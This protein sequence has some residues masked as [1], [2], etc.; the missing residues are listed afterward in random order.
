MKAKIMV[1]AAVVALLLADAPLHGGS[2][3]A[4]AKNRSQSLLTDDTARNVGDVLTIV[5]EEQSKIENASERKLEKSDS[6]SAKV[7]GPFDLLRGLNQ[8][9]GKLFGLDKMDFKSDADNKFD[10]KAQMDSSRKVEDKITVTVQD[11]LPNGNLVVLGSR[12]RK[13]TGDSQIVQVSG[14]VRPSDIT[15]ANAV[16]SKQVADFHIVY[17]SAGQENQTTNPGWLGR[18]LNLLNP[19]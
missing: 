2:I 12:T 15:Q 13:I 1:V 18:I 3:W 17:K 19:F 4:K 5:I 10:G 8:A 7:T 11:V 14:I 6:R 16:S 9:T